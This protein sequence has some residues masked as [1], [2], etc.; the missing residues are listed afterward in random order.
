M[1]VT[2]VTASSS[3]SPPFVLLCLVR[4]CVRACFESPSLPFLLERQPCALNAEGALSRY[5]GGWISTSV[6]TPRSSVGWR[7]TPSAGCQNLE[8]LWC[9]VP[10]AVV[11]DSGALLQVGVLSFSSLFS[12]FFF[13]AFSC[14]WA[15]WLLWPVHGY[16][17]YLEV[18]ASSVSISRSVVR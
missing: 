7:N 2:I 15:L 8:N 11:P 6:W 17:G 13:S 1:N 3:S 14:V 18:L 10:L 9:W 5:C 4:E 12:F 16:A